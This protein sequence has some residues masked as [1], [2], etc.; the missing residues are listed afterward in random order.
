MLQ[1][2]NK[3]VDQKLDV[4]KLPEEISLLS[5]LTEGSLLALLT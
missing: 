5:V 2:S 4:A 1:S 3:P